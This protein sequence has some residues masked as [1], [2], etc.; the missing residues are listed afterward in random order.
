MFNLTPYEIYVFILCLIV[1]I[2][3]T[4]LFTVMIVYIVRLMVKLIRNGVEDARI[5]KEYLKNKGKKDSAGWFDRLLTCVI[6]VG[7]FAVFGFSVYMQIFQDSVNTDIPM[8]RVVLSSSMSKKYEK[9]EYLF[10]ND[11][12]D[13]FDQF[14]LILTHK[15]P[16]EFDLELYDIVVYEVDDTLVVHRIVQIEEPNEKHPNE[17]HFRLQGDNVHLADKF[18]VKYSQMKAIYKGERIR[19]VGSFF[20]F[21]QSPAGYLCILL[22]IFGIVAI[23][24]MEKKIEKEELQR[25]RFLLTK[26]EQSDTGAMCTHGSHPDCPYCNLGDFNRYRIHIDLEYGYDGRPLPKN[27]AECMQP[28]EDEECPWYKKLTPNGTGVVSSKY[29]K[30]RLVTV[31][32]EEAQKKAESYAECPLRKR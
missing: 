20:A 13:Q 27:R 9:N 28:I 11:L 19:F 21:M 8:Y 17:R 30:Q 1:F 29:S 22:V 31:Q 15:L 10:E 4:V 12:N 23:P 32:V 2:A 16:D 26:K 5:W 25:L 6:C 14:D 7:L 18:P 3:L 24:L